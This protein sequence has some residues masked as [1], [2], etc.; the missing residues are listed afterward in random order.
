MSANRSHW[1]YSGLLTTAA[2]YTADNSFEYNGALDQ[3]RIHNS[4]ANSLRFSV[5][6][7]DNAVNDGEL[8]AGEE[9]TFENVQT[10]RV[11]V[12]NGTGATTARIWAY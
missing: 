8:L 10:N 1:F 12:K 5:K 7:R 2:T 3:L 4:G 9:K 11:A 6:G